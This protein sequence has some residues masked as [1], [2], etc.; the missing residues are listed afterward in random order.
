MANLV[1]IIPKN[2][3]QLPAE[4]GGAANATEQYKLKAML[5]EHPI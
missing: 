4:E 1:V 5:T 2:T 3:F